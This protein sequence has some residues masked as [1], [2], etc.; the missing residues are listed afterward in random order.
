M[1]VRSAYERLRSL[2]IAAIA[3]AGYAFPNVSAADAQPTLRVGV[4]GFPASLGNPYRGNGRPGTL[5]WY[6]LFDALTQL[7]ERGELVPALATSWE[8]VAPTRWQFTLREGVRFADGT[9]F[10]AH[11]A[12]AVIEWLRSDSG[13]S[14]VIGNEL[15]GVTAVHAISDRVLEI[16]TRDP[17]PILPKRMIG[18]LM[19]EPGAWNRLGPDSFALQPI[20][21]GPY[22]LERWDQ[23]TRRARARVNPHAWRTAGFVRLEFVELPEAAARTQALLSRDVDVALVEIEEI[24]RL[25]ARGYPVI[26][27]PSMSVMS[28]AFIT[29]RATAGPLQDVRVRQAL[30]L[31]VDRQTMARTLLRG[32]GRGAGQPA[33]PMSFGYE[34]DLPPYPYDPQRARE[35]LAEAGYP[36]GFALTA[37]VLINAFPADTLIYQA[38]AHYLRQVGVDVTLRLTTFA[39]YLRNLQRNTFT[40]DAFG[41]TWNS[42]PYN[43]AT[44]PME[45]FS[46]NRPRPF[47]CDRSLAQELRMASTILDENARLAALRTVARS[48]RQAVPALFLVEQVDLYAHS[49]RVA[50]MRLRNRVP[51]YEAIVPATSKDGDDYAGV[52]SESR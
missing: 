39:Q 36:R 49:P 21:T 46:C 18:A 28:L 51:V 4:N 7:D 31:A 35:L 42:A 13:R 38:M 26:A 5:I 17:D 41:A 9:T 22:V 25:E 2:V 10:D 29:E 11:S 14:T 27:A 37:D 30:N 45:G 44:R 43:D 50:N 34:P 8:L 48:Y 40:G 1:S 12:V 19:V 3:V 20:G 47:F 24:D 16:E 6:A 32:Y 33:T 52:H 23:R 15:R